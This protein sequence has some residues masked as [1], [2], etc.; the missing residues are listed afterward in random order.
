MGEENPVTLTDG[1]DV[2]VVFGVL[3]MRH[4]WL[5]QE[6]PQ[7]TI[8]S[9]NT[10]GLASPLLDPGTGFGPGLVQGEQSTLSSPLD[11]LVGLCDKLEARL[12][13]P[14]VCDLGLV[15][16]GRGLCVLG[17][18]ERCELGRWVVNRRGRERSRLDDGSACEVVVQNGL[19]IGL[20]D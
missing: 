17:E 16:N 9:L 3:G 13:Q 18:V 5:D 11:Q 8:N 2:D 4:E 10:L 20:E 12:Q 1:V 19:A 15:E 7:D 14:R 6:L